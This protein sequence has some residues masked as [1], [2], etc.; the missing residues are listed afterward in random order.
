MVKADMSKL[1]PEAK[2]LLLAKMSAK[3]KA[4]VKEV[5]TKTANRDNWI[6]SPHPNPDAKIKMFAFHYAGGAKSIYQNWWKDL[7]D[8]IEINTIQLPGREN[9]MNETPYTDFFP[10]VQALANAIEPHLNK[11]YVFFGHCMG[12]LTSFE[13]TRQLRRKNLPLPNHIYLSSMI[14]PAIPDPKSG[15]LRLGQE[16]IDDFFKIMKGTPSAVL[17]NLGLMRLQKP[18]LKADIDAIN[19]YDYI[20]EAPFDIPITT[21][22]GVNDDHVLADDIMDFKNQTTKEFKIHMLPGNH[23]HLLS[24]REHIMKLLNDS[25]KKV[26][27]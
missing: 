11:D 20:Q 7:P 1:S 13:L 24:H 23:F 25:L 16:T 3:K 6:E 8:N 14:N 18:L 27:N 19:S 5:E 9:R 17:E 4:A 10:M 22:G 2:K 15:I 26:I 21:F 12:A